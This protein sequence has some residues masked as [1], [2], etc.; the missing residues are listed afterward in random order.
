MFL[1]CWWEETGLGAEGG[2]IVVSTDAVTWGVAES[3]E[4]A[5][6]V[7]V[8]SDTSFAPSCSV[9][10]RL[11]AGKSVEVAE[12]AAGTGGEG[13]VES[14]RLKAITGGGGVVILLVLIWYVALATLKSMHQVK[15]MVNRLESL[16]FFLK[17]VRS[18]ICRAGDWF[19]I[20]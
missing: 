3:I 17:V 16:T 6:A 8:P 18:Q 13:E 9:L 5:G 1:F 20:F 11:V 4:I 19:F 12:R 14:A 2:R 15:M 7:D 10:T